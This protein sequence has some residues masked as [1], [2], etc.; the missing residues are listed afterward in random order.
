MEEDEDVVERGAELVGQDLEFDI[1]SNHG[2]DI[3]L[4]DDEAFA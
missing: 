2:E 3:L 4:D 1:V